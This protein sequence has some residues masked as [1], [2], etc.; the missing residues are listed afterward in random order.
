MSW[1][2]GDLAECLGVKSLWGSELRFSESSIRWFTDWAISQPQIYEMFAPVG[3]VFSVIQ[4]T[5]HINWPD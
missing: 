2:S 5:T 3:T 4:R 1:L